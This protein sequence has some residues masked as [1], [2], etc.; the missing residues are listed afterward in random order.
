[1]RLSVLMGLFVASVKE[2]FKQHAGFVS[3]IAPY[4]V[5]AE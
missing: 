2:F 5:K 4:R 3:E 1:M